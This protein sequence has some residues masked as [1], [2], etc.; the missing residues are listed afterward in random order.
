MI[1]E[2]DVESAWAALPF[3]SVELKQNSSDGAGGYLL[4]LH[5]GG[6][7]SLGRRKGEVY[8]SSYAELCFLIERLRV[9]EMRPQY[10][11]PGSSHSLYGAYTLRVT[12]ANGEEMIIEEREG[13]GPPELHALVAYIE[14]IKDY[15]RWTGSHVA[16]LN[17]RPRLVAEPW[18]VHSFAFPDMSLQGVPI[19]FS[20]EGRVAAE[21]FPEIESYL[22]T[23]ELELR[24]GGTEAGGR[25]FF[26]YDHEA[27]AFAS[28]SLQR[29]P[30]VI[31][32]AG[33]KFT[34]YTNGF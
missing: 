29:A 12:A 8:Y 18:Y 25:L 27:K 34:E 31:A 11:F 16:Q 9:A 33:F 28:R 15:T 32:P 14:S 3:V 22:L 6:E 2:E 23:A 30:I 20:A 4:R 13:W 21:C 1:R 19:E 7:A 10:G 26:T 17:L 24:L 5:R